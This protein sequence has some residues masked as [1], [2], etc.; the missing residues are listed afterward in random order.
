LKVLGFETAAYYHSL[1]NILASIGMRQG[2]AASVS[3]A[4]LRT[5]GEPLARRMGLWINLGDIMF[6]AATPAP[7]H[8]ST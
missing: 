4:A 1:H 2:A 8:S 3:R 5:I 6:V 7:R